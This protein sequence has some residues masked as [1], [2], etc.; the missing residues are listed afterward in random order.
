ME[1]Y[2]LNYAYTLIV[3]SRILLG[4][5]W[6]LIGMLVTFPIPIELHKRNNL[7]DTGFISYYSLRVHSASCQA[8]SSRDH[9]STFIC[10]FSQM[11]GPERTELW[12]KLLIDYNPKVLLPW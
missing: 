9:D 12:P 7:R 6:T 3:N 11:D 1:C 10:A 4:L 8:M 2:V 5:N